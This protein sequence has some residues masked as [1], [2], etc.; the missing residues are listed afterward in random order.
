MNT[1]AVT[2]ATPGARALA[3]CLHLLV[4]GLLT[5][6]AGRAVADAAP[7]AAAVVAAAAAVGLAY[8]SGGLL[9]RAKSP[10]RAAAAWLA[11]LAAAW[12]VLLALSADGVWLAFP[13]YFLPLHL[14]PRRAGL[15]AVTATMLAAIVGFAAHR[16]AVTLPVA[17]GPTLGAVV[18]VAVVWG[19]QALYRESEQRRRLIEQLTAA[20]AE[21]AAAEHT[22]GVLAERERLAREIHDTIA[23]GLSSIQLL[24]RAAERALPDAAGTAAGYVTQARQAA[25]D[26]LAEARRFVAALAPPALEGTTLA[27]ALARLCATTSARHRLAV[28]FHRAG[29]PVPLPTAQEVALLR[30]AQSALANTVRH[31]HATVAQV[32]LEYLDGQVAVDVVDD[33]VGFDAP[34]GEPGGG[35]FG[36][37]A[38]RA[39]VHALGGALKV[40]S[41]PGRGTAVSARLPVPVGDVPAGRRP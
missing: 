34:A 1:A 38:M 22:A 23:Q 35:G 31:A 15:V 36:L 19:Y 17:V 20:R 29:E 13:L 39:R 27:D 21:L 10:Q 33:G 37:A 9:P 5:L 8:A 12:L 6:A 7:H 24:L 4:A 40:R 18:A 30:V 11:L 3:W 2:T 28:G 14:L 16:G 32:R 41:T 25:V 26:N